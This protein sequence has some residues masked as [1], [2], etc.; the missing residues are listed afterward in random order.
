M[1]QLATFNQIGI[2][3]YSTCMK[4]VDGDVLRQSYATR[5]SIVVDLNG[6]IEEYCQR[7]D[8]SPAGGLRRQFNRG[9]KGDSG[10]ASA[11]V[12]RLKL[13]KEAA[14]QRWRD[15]KLEDL[16]ESDIL[17]VT[18]KQM[19]VLAF[20]AGHPLKDVVYV[21]DP[22]VPERYFPVSDF[23]RAMFDDKYTEVIRILRSLGAERIDIVYVHGFE[24]AGGVK[25]EVNTVPGEGHGGVQIT[26]KRK[27]GAT[28]AME[29]RPEGRPRLPRDLVWYRSEPLWQ[30]IAEARLEH[31]LHSFNLE[32]RYTEDFGVNSD[33]AAKIQKVGLNLGGD[34]RSF[35]ETVWK[36]SG[37]FRDE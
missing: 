29:L 30:E 14:A 34:F 12:K 20:P 4:F 26:S 1:R 27:L 18:A 10:V 6:S 23:H 8:P 3:R 16:I 15:R 24:R 21:A 36:I 19:R 28:L 5:Q 9:R 2:R 22:G 33:L 31:R 32:L 7:T 25:F 17:P 35:R 11:A 13:K 37:T